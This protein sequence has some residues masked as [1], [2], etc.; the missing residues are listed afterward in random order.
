MMMM[1][2]AVAAND[3]VD[4]D[5]EPTIIF[6]G[7]EEG[8]SSLFFHA[9]RSPIWKAVKH[10]MTTTAP[11]NTTDGVCLDWLDLVILAVQYTS[12]VREEDLAVFSLS[13]PA[14]PDE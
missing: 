1:M 4:D 14:V 5:E 7:R 13:L 9:H 6:L 10:H 12:V 8:D 3:D 2:A 11:F